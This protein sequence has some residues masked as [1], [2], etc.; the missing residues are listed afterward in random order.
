MLISMVVSSD[1]FALN[2]GQTP[3]W[4]PARMTDAYTAAASLPFSFKLF[5]SFD[6]SVGK[7]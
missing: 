7:R 1:G 4:E 5:L 6:M 2:L 3:D